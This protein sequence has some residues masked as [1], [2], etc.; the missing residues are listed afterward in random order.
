MRNILLPDFVKNKINIAIFFMV[1][2]FSFNSCASSVN[3]YDIQKIEINVK[4]SPNS[5][6]WAWQGATEKFPAGYIQSEI[7]AGKIVITLD[8]PISESPLVKIPLAV[9]FAERRS[10]TE[11][12]GVMTMVSGES[13]ETLNVYLSQT[14]NFPGSPLP[15]NT[16][17]GEGVICP[18]TYGSRLDNRTFSVPLVIES[19]QRATA[20]KYTTRVNGYLWLE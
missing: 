16:E 14:A 5:A 15:C 2:A 12:K 8:Y 3:M 18:L 17:E 9:S 7:N 10:D 11:A 13:V 6:Y 1:F 19:G 4:A 20:G